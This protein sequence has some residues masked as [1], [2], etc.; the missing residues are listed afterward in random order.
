MIPAGNGAVLEMIWRTENLDPRMIKG[1][2][3]VRW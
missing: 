3:M 2:W 1:T